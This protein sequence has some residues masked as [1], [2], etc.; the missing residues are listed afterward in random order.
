MRETAERVVGTDEAAVGVRNRTL[1][2]ADVLTCPREDEAS[3]NFPPCTELLQLESESF[4][5]VRVCG[6]SLKVVSY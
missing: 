3:E 2:F 4:A 6:R 5:P 1:L